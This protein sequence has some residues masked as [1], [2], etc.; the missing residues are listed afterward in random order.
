MHKPENLILVIFGASGDLTARKLLPALLDLYNQDLMPDSFAILGV[1]RT[2]Y[3][4]ESFRDKM[5]DRINH[6]REDLDVNIEE[7]KNF[8]KHLYYQHIDTSNND[9][10]EK[11]KTKLNDLNEKLNTKSNFI[12]YL[13][14]PPSLYD[15]IPKFIAQ[16]GLNK[17]KSGWRRLIIEKPFG[18][19]LD[20]AV[21]L[22]EKLLQNYNEDQLYRI[23]HYLGKETVQN[24]L[25]TRFS[26]GIYEPL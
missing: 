19:D 6:F 7:I 15:I 11:V 10:Y 3:S 17:S 24:L 8:A 20:S 9:D 23:D 13:S 4:D 5:V 26:N 12:F 22:N 21:Q 18:Y 25:V 1:S 16:K 2:K 14:T